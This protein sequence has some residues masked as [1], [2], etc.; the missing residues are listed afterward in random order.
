MSTPGDIREELL[1]SN[2]EFQRLAQEHSRYEAE[3]DQITRSPFL[4]A[5]DLIQEIELKK[6]RLQVKDQMERIW[7]EIRRKSPHSGTMAASSR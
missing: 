5:E 4:S 3:L 1:A 6:L 2:P 7:A